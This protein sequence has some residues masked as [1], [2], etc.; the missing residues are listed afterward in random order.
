LALGVVTDFGPG[1]AAASWAV[2]GAAIPSDAAS[3]SI[4][5][6]RALDIMGGKMAG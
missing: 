5:I 3:S 6:K 4:F 1:T 2:I